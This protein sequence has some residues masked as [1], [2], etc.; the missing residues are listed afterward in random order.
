MAREE[1]D[2]EDLLAEAKVLF[3]RASLQVAGL[4]DPIVA[5]FRRDGGAAFY[6]GA[7]R[8][9][10]FTSAGELRRAFVEPLLYKAEEGRLV[11]LRRKRTAQS[12][13]LV[14]HELNS[15]EERAFL[16]EMR[17]NL[18]ALGRALAAGDFQLHA[19]VPDAGDVI[20]R[21]QAWVTQFADRIV[22]ARGPR[23]S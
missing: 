18:A 22:I 8:V 20:G 16:A 14:R 23:A 12:V 10:Q 13:N 2:R 6:F 15:A 19:Q 17:Q 7:D 21:L 4:A 5:G 3:E 11:A 9:Y 1:H